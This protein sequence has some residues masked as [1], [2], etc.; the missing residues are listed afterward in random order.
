MKEPANMDD[1]WAFRCP[2]CRIP[3]TMP[4]LCQSCDLKER[5]KRERDAAEEETGRRDE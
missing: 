5:R 3:R 4:G 1:Q 2:R